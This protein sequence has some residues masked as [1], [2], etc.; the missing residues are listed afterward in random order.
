[1]LA[2]LAAFRLEVLVPCYTNENVFSA[3]TRYAQG[4]YR[5]KWPVV[6]AWNRSTCPTSD[7]FSFVWI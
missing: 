2:Y 6:T 5:C 7:V 3:F 1:M 4:S